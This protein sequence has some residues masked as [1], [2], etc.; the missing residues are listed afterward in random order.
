[1][2]VNPGIRTIF[3]LFWKGDLSRNGKLNP[4][5]DKLTFP[6]GNLPEVVSLIYTFSVHIPVN[7]EITQ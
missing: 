7:K 4:F 3:V 5:L 1:M 6:A 2:R